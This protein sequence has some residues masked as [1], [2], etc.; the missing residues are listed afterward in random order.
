MK[1]LLTGLFFLIQFSTAYSQQRIEDFLKND[2]QVTKV[3]LLGTF[4]FDNPNLDTYK[5]KNK[6]NILDSVRQRQVLE[7]VNK[8]SQFKP[9]LIC[10]EQTTDSL[11]NDN[12]TRYI[13]SEYELN[14]SEAEQLGFRIAKANKLKKV[15]AIDA[16]SYFRE[17]LKKVASLSNIWDEKFYLD[18]AEANNWSKKYHAWYSHLE[19]RLQ[20]T[21]IADYLKI[22]NQPENLKYNLGQY[23]VENKTSNH[24]GPDFIALDWYDRNLRIFNNVLKANPGKEDRILVIFGSGHIPILQH[25]FESSP[26]FELVNVLDYL[27]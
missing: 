16:P 24:N 8:I 7:T 9:T 22:L 13:K 25:L 10:L 23:L 2:G 11:L 15:F 6:I 5:S 4:H 26:Q 27:R 1:Y 20:T 12:Y 21:S 3:M 17:N 18:T 19:S 14:V